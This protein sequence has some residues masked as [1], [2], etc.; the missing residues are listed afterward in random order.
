MALKYEYLGCANIDPSR[1]PIKAV[2]SRL[3]PKLRQERENLLAS[4]PHCFLLLDVCDTPTSNLEN[5]FIYI[6]MITDNSYPSYKDNLEKEIEATRSRAL[7]RIFFRVSNKLADLSDI[8][9]SRFQL[10]I[11]AAKWLWFWWYHRQFPEDRIKAQV[12]KYK[13][14]AQNQLESKVR[15][16]FEKCRD[17]ICVA[18][19]VKINTPYRVFWNN[20][21][22]QLNLRRQIAHE[23]GNDPE[24]VWLVK[25]VVP[26]EN[27]PE[28]FPI[29]VLLPAKDLD[30]FRIQSKL[31]PD[32]GTTLFFERPYYISKKY[33]SF[34][35]S[36]YVS[37]M[38]YLVYG[39]V[40]EITEEAL[41]KL[42]GKMVKLAYKR[43]KRAPIMVFVCYN[44]LQEKT[45]KDQLEYDLQ[46]LKKCLP[47]CNKY[48][49]TPVSRKPSSNVS[50]AIDKSGIVIVLWGDKTQF[51]GNVKEEFECAQQKNKPIILLDGRSNPMPDSHLTKG[52]KYVRWDA[53]ID[54][55]KGFTGGY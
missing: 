39:Y 19:W 25:Q 15:Q 11:K 6:A 5:C 49:I 29:L 1:L 50:N 38:D 34:Y 7:Y 26:L 20:A 21:A 33:F 30:K 40:E 24:Y 22:D 4:S 31:K 47:E 51:L 55:W 2:L 36:S 8:P 48:K 41:P 32:Q 17:D 28:D 3:D 14:T 16:A 27:I 35:V 23:N 42:A 54:V 45:L 18:L 9:E 43:R 46:V 44:Y 12:N 10:V 13:R 53:A 52:C 37:F